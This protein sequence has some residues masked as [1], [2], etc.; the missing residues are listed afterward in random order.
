MGFDINQFKNK[1]HLGNR[2][3]KRIQAIKADGQETTCIEKAVE[4]ALENINKSN[5]RSFVV[6]GEP[7]SGKT[8]MMIALTAK[9]LDEGNKI[10][11]HL[12]NDNVSLLEQNLYRFQKS[13]LAPAPRNYI[14]VLDKAIEIGSKEWVIFC[15]KN[16]SDL[17]KL[18]DKLGHIDGKVIIDDE[19][20]YA[21]PNSKIN[22]QKQSKMNELITKLLK[23]EGVFIGV[24]ATP[25]RLD[26]NNT[27][28][29][30]HEKWV[31]FQPHSKYTGQDVFFPI[32]R[33]HEFKIQFIPD[34]AGDEPK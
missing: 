29:N 20:D 23:N 24:T 30:E 8:E 1:T 21:T 16:A 5:I 6:Y 10:I 31:D 22:Q 18:I 12:L 17:N 19:A 3:E 13:G 33:K 28:E 15:K 26:L 25:A 34:N 11:I 7:Q 32:N 27:F 2:Y 14:A 9:L 4:E